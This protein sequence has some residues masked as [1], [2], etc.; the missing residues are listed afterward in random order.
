VVAVALLATGGVLQ[1]GT[2]SPLG[3]DG[4]AGE[5][6]WAVVGKTPTGLPF[7]GNVVPEVVSVVQ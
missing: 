6:F 7:V 3:R 4:A 5:Q 2:V 1:T